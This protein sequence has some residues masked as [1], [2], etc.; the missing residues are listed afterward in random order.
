MSCC[1]RTGQK[2][3]SISINNMSNSQPKIHQLIAPNTRQH[4]HWFAYKQVN[5][6]TEY[7]HKDGIWKNKSFIDDNNHAYFSDKN[8]LLGIMNG[9]GNS[10]NAN[11]IPQGQSVNKSIVINVDDAKMIKVWKYDDAPAEIKNLHNHAVWVAFSP[12]KEIP[13]WCLGNSP[14]SLNEIIIKEINNGTVIFGV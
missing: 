7:L 1:S 3:E 12:T 5:S 14:F 8:E 9:S 6:V 2:S 10:I 13:E 11:D 4:L